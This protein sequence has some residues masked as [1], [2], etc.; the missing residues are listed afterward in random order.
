MDCINKLQKQDLNDS[1]LFFKMD[2]GAIESALDLK[3]EGKKLRIMN[4]IKEIRAKYEKEGSI[5]YVDQ[6]L[7]DDGPDAP[8]LKIVRSSTLNRAQASKD[9]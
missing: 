4:K 3:P 5:I 7:L 8:A 1:E 2:I 9:F 6:G